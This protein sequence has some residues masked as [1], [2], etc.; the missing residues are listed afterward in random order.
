MD[1]WEYTRH[2]VAVTLVDKN[3]KEF[4]KE[5]WELVSIN[6]LAESY[7]LV[8]KRRIEEKQTCQHLFYTNANGENRC[9]RCRDLHSN[10]FPEPKP[11]S[12]IDQVWDSR[13]FDQTRTYVGRV[14]EV[15]MRYAMALAEAVESIESERKTMFH[16]T[17]EG[18]SVDLK[19]I[20]AILR[21][22]KTREIPK[23]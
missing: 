1:K 19:S 8:F 7:N 4:G 9:R 11:K 17:S 10:L 15:E 5:G 22:E 20:L 21:G 3:L 14:P 16:K 13:P 6:A 2:S 18:Y 23:P 12:V